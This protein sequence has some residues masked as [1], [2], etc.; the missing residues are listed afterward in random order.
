MPALQLVLV[1]E[2]QG[3][4]LIVRVICTCGG[5]NERGNLPGALGQGWGWEGGSEILAHQTPAHNKFP[6]IKDREWGKRGLFL[7]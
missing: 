4:I 3:D 2:G 1:S 5:V 6:R 7:G